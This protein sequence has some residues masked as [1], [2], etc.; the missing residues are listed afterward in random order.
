MLPDNARSSS[1]ARMSGS[2]RGGGGSDLAVLLAPDVERE[3]SVLSFSPPS[4]SPQRR[5]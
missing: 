2:V 3:V 5:R 4:S 1:N